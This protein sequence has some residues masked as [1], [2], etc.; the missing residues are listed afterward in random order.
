M[1]VVRFIQEI[2]EVGMLIPMKNNDG[3]VTEVRKGYSH[4]TLKQYIKACVD[5]HNKQKTQYQG[6]L[7][8]A[9][10]RGET[11]KSFE[12]TLK[13][14]SAEGRQSEDYVDPGIGSIQD[15][16]NSEQLVS[17]ADYYLQRE[18]M[19]GAA[20]R[21]RMVLLLN[22]M[23]ML[24]G[25]TLRS[26]NLSHIFP[27][28][29]KDEGATRC[30][31]FVMMITGGKTNQEG[32][33]LYS[34]VIRHKNVNTCAFGATGFYLFHRFHVQGEQFPDFSSNRNWFNIKLARGREAEKGVSYNTQLA[35]VNKAFTE[36]GINSKKKTYSGRQAG[37]REAEMAGLSLD[38]IRRVG[39]WNAESMENNYLTCLPRTAIRVI[40]GFPE[41]RGCFWLPRALVDPP[42]SLKNMIFPDVE[43]WQDKMKQNEEMQTICG[44]GFLKLLVELRAII[45]QDAVILHQ[46]M[47]NHEIFNHEIF[48]SEEYHSFERELLQAI[49]SAT[50]P[51]E[52]EMQR[53]V[54]QINDRI[55][56]L[57]Q[58]IRTTNHQQF[59]GDIASSI[60]STLM[61]KIDEKLENLLGRSENSSMA[62]TTSSRVRPRHSSDDEG[63]SMVSYRLSRD[64]TTVTSLWKEWTAG[65][66]P[67]LPSVQELNET[68]GTRWRKNGTGNVI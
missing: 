57:A 36:V 37:A 58:Q 48:R 50:P 54:P 60:C 18:K 2:Y 53:V 47:P 22:H 65:L 38:H 55:N 20:L 44:E 34:G 43:L 19:A 29:F 32:H 12:S 24:R 49:S 33:K 21:D 40:H 46:T 5:L 17:V 7:S 52:V 8:I 16:Y 25:E 4:E 6:T 9:H 35:S 68:F 45:L 59:A 41:E 66:S 56:E 51:A 39:R 61:Q 31:V 14:L 13:K 1:K 62:P 15:G 42:V 63:E 23:M 64:I 10:P 27:L 11:L 30:P 26:A 3:S 67:D 28:E